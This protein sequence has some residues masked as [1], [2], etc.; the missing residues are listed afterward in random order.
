L[1]QLIELRKQEHKLL[2]E[3]LPNYMIGE[4]DVKLSLDTVDLDSSVDTDKDSYL[5]ADSTQIEITIKDNNGNPV[6]GEATVA[7]IDEALLALKWDNSV[8]L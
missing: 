4:L 2:Q 5:P 6:N 3:I 8:S 7:V 1:D